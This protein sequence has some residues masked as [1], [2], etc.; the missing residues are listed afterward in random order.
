MDKR[1]VPL[2]AL[3]AFCADVRTSWPRPLK[4]AGY[5]L[6]AL[7]FP[8]T[9]E[10]TRVVPDVVAWSAA[11]GHF[12]VGE[13]KSGPNVDDLLD[14]RHPPGDVRRRGEREESGPGRSV[15]RGHDVV[16]GERPVR[17]ALHVPARGGARPRQHVRV[18]LYHRRHD[19]IIDVKVQSIH[20][21][22]DGFGRVATDDRHIIAALSTGE[23]QRGFARI[24]VLGGRHLGLVARP[25]VNA[26]I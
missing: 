14:G 17:G 1:F 6:S 9:S 15:Q 4:D 3:I 20:E 11:E 16:D 5:Q 22:V 24:L 7:E 19:N 21:M 2:N 12:A 18:V 25:S 8:V 10:E 23:A 26:R 13:A